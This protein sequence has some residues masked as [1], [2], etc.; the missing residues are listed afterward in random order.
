M[1]S[2]QEV[3]ERSAISV[4]LQALQQSL[5]T[6]TSLPLREP[7][8]QVITDTTSIAMSPDGRW[9]AL[10]STDGYIQIWDQTTDINGLYPVFDEYVHN[11][12]ITVVDFS[13]DGRWL[14]TGSANGVIGLLDMTQKPVKVQRDTVQGSVLALAFHPTEGWLAVSQDTKQVQR[15]E[16]PLQAENEP[17]ILLESPEESIATLVFSPF[18]DQLATATTSDTLRIWSLRSTLPLVEDA[19][20]LLSKDKNGI[21]AFSPDGRWL[22]AGSREKPS[23][24]LYDFGMDAQE[25]QPLAFALPGH[26]QGIKAVSFSPESHLLAVGGGDGIVRLWDL[27]ELDTAENPTEDQAEVEDESTPSDIPA[28]PDSPFAALNGADELPSVPAN[29]D[30]IQLPRRPQEIRGAR[31]S[32]ARTSGRVGI[33]E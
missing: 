12:P 20:Q 18:G 5:A 31:L 25:H 10:A 24:T 29:L 15:I 16:V 30:P 9:L 19:S 23:V 22:A 13:Q 28:R 27:R 11:G 33:P 32:S 14:A 17:K 8:G 26:E 2:G 4:T 6:T 3:D 21:V 7:T 1:Q